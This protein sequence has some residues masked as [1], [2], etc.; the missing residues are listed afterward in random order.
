MIG[1]IHNFIPVHSLLV[2]YNNTYGNN[3]ISLRFGCDYIT[4]VSVCLVYWGMKLKFPSSKVQCP[5]S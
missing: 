5:D 4:G 3:F 2:T 1:Y